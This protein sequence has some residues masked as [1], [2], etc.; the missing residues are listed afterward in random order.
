MYVIS[1]PLL[2]VKSLMDLNMM[3]ATASLSTPYPNNTELSV[4]ASS[5]FMIT[6][7]P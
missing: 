6:H 3:I 4:G 1:S 2:A 7:V 5:G